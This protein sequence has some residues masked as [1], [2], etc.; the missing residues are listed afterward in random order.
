MSPLQKTRKLKMIEQK[1][2]CYYCDLP[3]WDNSSHLSAGGKKRTASLKPALR[4]TAEHLLARCDG[5]KDAAANI[6]AAC[7]FCNTRRH[8]RKQP[9][10]PEKYRRHV[11]KRMSAGSWLSSL[12]LDATSQTV[13]L[14]K[15][16]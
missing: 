4:C 13:H 3:M 7:M 8:M 5:G 2:R 15:N 10:S 12:K 14:D 1:G 6:V 16:E 9:L 11:Q